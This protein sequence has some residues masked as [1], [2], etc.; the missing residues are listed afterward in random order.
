[1]AAGRPG[2]ARTVRT[3]A[4]RDDR[5]PLRRDPDA[6]AAGAVRPREAG[7]LRPARPVR[8]GELL[9]RAHGPRAR[10]RASRA[11]RPA[12]TRPRAGAAA[13]RDQ[14]PPLHEPGGRQGPLGAAL[15]PV[16]VHDDGPEPVQVRHRRLLPQEPCRDAPHLARAPRGLRQHPPHRRDVRH[17]VHRGRGPL[18]A[19]VPLPAGGERGELVR[20][21]GPARPRRALP[22]RASRTTPSGRRSSRPTSSSPRGMP[23]TSSSSPT[24]SP[25]PRTTASAW[26]RAAVPV[27]G[28]CVRTR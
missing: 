23:G 17:L 18:H 19:A 21:G 22:R 4:H 14:R 1:M 28:R 16:R 5:L 26:A 7:G 24:S 9:L 11:A 6:P 20:Q 25:G 3:R 8:A 10:H 15:C 27:P 12:P 13:R 2:A